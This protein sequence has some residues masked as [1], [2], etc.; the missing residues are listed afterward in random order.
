V[1]IFMLNFKVGDVVEQ[2]DGTQWK[3]MGKASKD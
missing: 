1:I 2:G 3:E